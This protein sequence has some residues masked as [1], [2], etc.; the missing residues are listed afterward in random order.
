MD[1]DTDAHAVIRI[2]CN[3]RYGRFPGLYTLDIDMEIITNH[4]AGTFDYV[5]IIVYRGAVAVI[6]ID[7]NRI[8]SPVNKDDSI[9]YYGQYD[10]QQNYE[11]FD[12]NTCSQISASR[13]SL[14]EYTIVSLKYN[15][16]FPEL[17]FFAT[18][19]TSFFV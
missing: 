2:I 7:V 12:K 14:T 4:S 13:K 8:L 17:C 5:T 3:E 9:R 15:T 1:I 10:R 19:R 16:P 18:S 6:D 11:L